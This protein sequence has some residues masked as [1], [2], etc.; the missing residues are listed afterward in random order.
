[1]I[2]WGRLL[3]AAAVY[4]CLLPF[5][6][7]CFCLL[8]LAAIFA[9]KC[10]QDEPWRPQNGPKI[11]LKSTQNGL[12]EPPGPPRWNQNPILLYWDRFWSPIW[13]PKGPQN[14]PKIETLREKCSKKCILKAMLA[15]RVASPHFLSLWEAFLVKKSMKFST[16]CCASCCRF[17]SLKNHAFYR[18]PCMWTVFLEICWN[19]ENQP[20]KR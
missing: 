13:S 4:C 10:C 6:A 14:Q 5:L 1:M 12:L 3:F 7:I 11:D 19:R 2:C 16:R 17:P 18:L 8:L 15:W 20:K 9:P